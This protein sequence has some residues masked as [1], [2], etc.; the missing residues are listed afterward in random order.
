MHNIC[1]Y[2]VSK[3]CSL[4]YAH[5][6]SINETINSILHEGSCGNYIELFLELQLSN[7]EQWVTLILFKDLTSFISN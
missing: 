2:S 6:K 5:V 1:T 4:S 3:I 7:K